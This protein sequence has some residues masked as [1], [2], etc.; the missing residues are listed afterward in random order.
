MGTL[1][2]TFTDIQ[3]S[4]TIASNTIN[5]IKIT[6]AWNGGNFSN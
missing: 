2:K 3:E 5:I 6:T 1:I 4:F